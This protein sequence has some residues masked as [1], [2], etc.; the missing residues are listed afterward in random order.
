MAL[1]WMYPVQHKALV[2]AVPAT[3]AGYPLGQLGVGADVKLAPKAAV[4]LED[5]LPY[6][7]RRTGGDTVALLE[8]YLRKYAGPV[9]GH[10]HRA[11][12]QYLVGNAVG[13]VHDAEVGAAQEKGDLCFELAWQPNVVRVEEGNELA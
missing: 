4:L 13:A 2:D 7:H 12:S 1:T 8:H 9:F 11:N 3:V 6:D 5:F 10:N